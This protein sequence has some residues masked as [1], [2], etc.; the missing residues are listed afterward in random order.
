MVN[1]LFGWMVILEGVSVVASN[2]HTGT[3]IVGFTSARWV[4]IVLFVVEILF[5]ARIGVGSLFGRIFILW[6]FAA[7]RLSYKFFAAWL[8]SVRVFRWLC[9]GRQVFCSFLLLPVWIWVVCDL[10]GRISEHRDD[11][12]ELR[13]LAVLDCLYVVGSV[14]TLFI[15]VLEL[16][17]ADSY[18]SSLSGW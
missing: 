11:S 13:G 7:W 9:L 14:P 12:R 17:T 4:C 8:Q 10:D 3:L 15:Y 18:G 2:L 5:S 1:L 6:F 16:S